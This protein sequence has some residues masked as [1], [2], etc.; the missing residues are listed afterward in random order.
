LPD[1][2]LADL[3]PEDRSP[4]FTFG[5]DDPAQPVTLVAVDQDVVIGFAATGA[6]RDDDARGRGE[7]LALYVDPQSWGLG[8]GCELLAA[9][10]ARLTEQRFLEAVLW[11]LVGNDRAQRLYLVDGWS[12]DGLR[13]RDEVWGVTVDEIRYRRSLP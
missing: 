12:A 3:R 1:D 7:L 13:R 8:V 11:V 2:Y 10:R 6:A 4:P 5:G 9:A